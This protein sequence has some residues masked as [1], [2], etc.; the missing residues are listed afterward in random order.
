MQFPLVLID[1][2]QLPLSIPF[3]FRICRPYESDSVPNLH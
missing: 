3:N 1:L 2:L